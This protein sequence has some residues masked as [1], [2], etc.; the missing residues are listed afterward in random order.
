MRTIPLAYPEAEFLLCATACR[1]PEAYQE[2]IHR[3]LT[4][5][6]NFDWARLLRLAAINRVSSLLYKNLSRLEP[7]PVPAPILAQLRQQYWNNS[8]W[9]LQLKAELL[10]VVRAFAV[11]EIP[12]LPLKGPVLAGL[13]YRDPT[14]RQ[15][16][17]LDILVRW[18]HLPQAKDSLVSLGYALVEENEGHDFHSTFQHTANKTCV[19]LHWQ[20]TRLTYRH[21]GDGTSLWQDAKIILWENTPIWVPTAENLFIYLCIHACRHD[22]NRLQWISDIPHLLDVYPE[23]NWL[24]VVSEAK[25]LCVYRMLIATLRLADDLYGITLPD[26]LRQSLSE[27]WLSKQEIQRISDNLFVEAKPSSFFNEVFFFDSRF[28]LLPY[29]WNCFLKYYRSMPTEVDFQWVSLPRSLHFLYYIVHPV[30]LMKQYG[31][32][33]RIQLLKRFRQNWT[34]L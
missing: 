24:F 33:I 9:S 2:N 5:S 1:L 20:P 7:S 32:A 14:R 11:V 10:R 31:P 27:S 13:Y 17:D 19:E 34:V 28:S 25:R 12:V 22:W 15:F 4:Q 8:L 21:Y 6:L 18:E 30:R 26:E 16:A 3:L 29:S 23:M